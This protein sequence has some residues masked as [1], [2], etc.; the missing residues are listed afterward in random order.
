MDQRPYP[1]EKARG[2]EIILTTPL[3]R[4]VFLAGLIGAVGLVIIMMMVR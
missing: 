1:A 3:P 2:G 4:A